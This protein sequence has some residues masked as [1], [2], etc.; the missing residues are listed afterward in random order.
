[1]KKWHRWHRYDING[2]KFIKNFPNDITPEDIPDEGYTCWT[3]GT[4]PFTPETLNKLCAMNQSLWKGVPKSIEQK[5]KMRL[6]KLGVPK[7]D[8]H[9]QNLR[10]AWEQRKKSISTKTES[11]NTLTGNG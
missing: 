9:K 4:G 7:S 8:S 2:N 6:A 3:K 11:I 10:K 1:M 5:E